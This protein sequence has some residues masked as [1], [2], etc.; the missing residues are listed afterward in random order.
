MGIE[1]ADSAE[2]H[3]PTATHLIVPVSCAVPNRAPGAPK[4]SGENQVRAVPG[5]KL[6]AILGTATIEER[7]FCNYEVN[8]AFRP[9]LEAAGMKISAVGHQGETRAIELATHPFFVA[10]LFQPQ[11]TSKATGQPH[12]LIRAFLEATGR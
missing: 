4:L 7:Y 10:T 6:A 5:T 8:D 1:D 9:R 3:V 12:P 2:H 11:L